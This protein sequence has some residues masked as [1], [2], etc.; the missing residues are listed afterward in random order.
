MTNEVTNENFLTLDVLNL[1]NSAS[2]DDTRYHLTGLYINLVDQVAVA[3]DG[4]Q[5]VWM[6]IENMHKD[7]KELAVDKN[8]IIIPKEACKA[9]VKMLKSDPY[10]QSG[11]LTIT[12]TTISLKIFDQVAS[13][14]LIEGEFPAYKAVI[15]KENGQQKY[16]L[17]PMLVEKVRKSFGIKP[18]DSEGFV[19]LLPMT[20][21]EIDPNKPCIIK[22]GDKQAVIMPMRM[23]E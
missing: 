18:K 3:T 11:T 6:P 7:F 15:P 20:G 21:N 19:F 13:F 1:I 14:G 17:N 12:A 16:C 23:Q 4:H 10:K 2:T 5:L 8:S 9:F 22:C